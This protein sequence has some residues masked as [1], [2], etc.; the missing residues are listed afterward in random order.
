[1]SLKMSIIEIKQSFAYYCMLGVICFCIGISLGFST[2]IVEKLNRLVPLEDWSAD[3]V[4]L[5]KGV[6]LSDL[7]NDLI[8]GVSK[9]FLPKVLYDTTLAMTEGQVQLSVI[10]AHKKMDGQVVIGT[11]SNVMSESYMGVKWLSGA[12]LFVPWSE[13]LATEIH[14]VWKR[15]LM[16]AMFAKGS[17]ANMKK[18]KDIID[19]KTVAQA[20]FISD[21]V[22]KNQELASKLET[23]ITGLYFIFSLIVFSGLLLVYLSIKGRLKKIF[24]VLRERGYSFHCLSLFTLFLFFITVCFPLFI[25]IFCSKI[26]VFPFMI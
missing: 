21:E 20:F 10:L 12:V 8:N 23:S 7:K 6:T 24:L 18:L 14:P 11:Q 15:S 5:P 19:Q 13:N 22:K 25:G 2:K 4:V 9:A 1:M 16:S 26:F 3:L 17:Y